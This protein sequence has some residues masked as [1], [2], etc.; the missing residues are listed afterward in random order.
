MDQQTDGQTLSGIEL[1]S[2]TRLTDFNPALSIEKTL[3]C[4]LSGFKRIFQKKFKELQYHAD[5][6]KIRAHFVAL[7]CQ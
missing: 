4:A 6:K 7:F 2:V 1:H 3:V 5:A